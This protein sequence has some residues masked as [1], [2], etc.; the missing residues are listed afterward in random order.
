MAS[1]Y[2]SAPALKKIPEP[3]SLASA[4]KYKK[5]EP[6]SLAL[7]PE[8]K[9]QSKKLGSG[10]INFL[11]LSI[12]DSWEPIKNVYEKPPGT[13]LSQSKVIYHVENY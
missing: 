4:P 13:I 3:K 10:S 9:N 5:S 11:G 2:S 6:K 7:A 8:L 12:S 1:F